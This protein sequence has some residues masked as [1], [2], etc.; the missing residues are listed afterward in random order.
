MKDSGV[1][2]KNV[3]AQI[4]AHLALALT[5]VVAMCQGVFSADLAIPPRPAPAK[6]ISVQAGPPD[7]S[8][9]TDE[10]VN[11]TR[12]AKG[13]AAVCSN[14]GFACQPKAVRCLGTP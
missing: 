8:R 2:R 6:D 4:A 1:R 11:C 5:V 9:W 10:C 7:C 12:S 13:E 14:T 3:R